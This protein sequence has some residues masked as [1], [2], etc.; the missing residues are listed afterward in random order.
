MYLLWSK[1][2]KIIWSCQY[3]PLMAVERTTVVVKNITKT[4]KNRR[5]RYDTLTSF[6]FDYKSWRKKTIKCVKDQIISCYRIEEYYIK[7]QQ[8]CVWNKHILFQVNR[9][10]FMFSYGVEYHFQ[11]YFCYIVAFSFTKSGSLR[12]S[13]FSGCWLILSVYIIMSFDFPFVRLFGVR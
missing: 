8:F 11:Q 2:S 7:C 3:Q 5:S 10:L 1:S 4:N 6:T 9:Y 12:F 13:Q